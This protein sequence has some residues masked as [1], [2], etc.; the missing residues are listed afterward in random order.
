MNIWEKKIQIT[1]KILKFIAEIDEFKGSWAAIGK[2]AP[3]KLT[4]LKKVA[5][6]ESIASSTRIEGAKLSDLEVKNLL[7]GLNI[8]SLKNR[9]E[10]EIAGYA[11]LMKLIFEFHQDLTPNENIIKQLHQILLKYSSKDIPHRGEY[12]KINNNV[13]AIGPDGR[14]LGIIFETVSP[15]ETPAKMESLVQWL[16]T[17]SEDSHPLIVISIFTVAFLAIHPFQD[18]NGRLSRALTSLL[19]LRAGYDYTPFSSLERVI[20]VNKDFYYI[21]LREAQTEDIK[22]TKG[23]EDW[24]TFF[25][26]CLIKQKNAL[27]GKVEK[28][29]LLQG[30]SQLGEQILVLLKDHE[31]LSIGDLVKLTGANRNTIKS[32]LASLVKTGDI[33][34]AGKGKGSYYYL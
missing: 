22:S 14:S 33:R 21:R 3:E 6:I 29:K 27:K 12:K 8:L 10:E 26:E 19:L 24:I 15:L 16:N 25:L 2:L 32:Q 28:E 34:M 31:N 20:E 17:S 30:I 5:T 4:T 11:E 13:E 1:P 9:D 18:G 7:S 23:L